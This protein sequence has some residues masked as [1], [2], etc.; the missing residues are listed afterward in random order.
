[1]TIAFLLHELLVR[2][3]SMRQLENQTVLQN[4]TL[5]YYIYIY[6]RSFVKLG[7][8][9]I[10]LLEPIVTDMQEDVLSCVHRENTPEL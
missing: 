1:M 9:I 10:T 6:I 7:N 4:L 3:L 2:H 5:L 8:T